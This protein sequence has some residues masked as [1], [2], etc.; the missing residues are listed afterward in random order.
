MQTIEERI[1]QIAC[2][3]DCPYEQIKFM[4]YSNF[5][6]DLRTPEERLKIIEDNLGIDSTKD[7][8]YKDLTN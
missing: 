2:K 5:G 3:Y 8:P 4:V 7:L 1:H 6:V